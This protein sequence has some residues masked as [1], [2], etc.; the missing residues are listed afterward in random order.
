MTFERFLV[1][2]VPFPFTDVNASKKR[3]ALIL[4]ESS[5]FNSRMRKSVM[6]MVTTKSNPAW[7]LDV[8]LVD[9]RAIGLRTASIV[10]MKL[11][12]LD[13]TL[14]VRQLGTLSEQDQSA[15]TVAVRE[16]FGQ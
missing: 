1:V 12:T 4:S 5:S 2:V 14:I 6:A 3:P 13:N 9:W 7:A 15:V 10:R 8:H 16:L 11:F